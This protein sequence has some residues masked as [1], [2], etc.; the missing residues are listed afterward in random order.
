MHALIHH[1]LVKT[2]SFE[3]AFGSGVLCCQPV[4]TVECGECGVSA[5]FV[6]SELIHLVLRTGQYGQGLNTMF[7]H[8]TRV[9]LLPGE[10]YR[11]F[12]PY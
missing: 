9:Q 7:V 6:L 5:S 8:L 12:R 1:F 10:V 3:L 4:T 2:R 11:A